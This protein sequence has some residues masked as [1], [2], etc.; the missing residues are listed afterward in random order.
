MP[1][2]TIF[3][4]IRIGLSFENLSPSSFNSDFLKISDITASQVI[5]GARSIDIKAIY[6]NHFSEFILI[7]SNLPFLVS[8]IQ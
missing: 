3:Q 6:R 4:E 2:S 7:S 5:C 1:N 8:I